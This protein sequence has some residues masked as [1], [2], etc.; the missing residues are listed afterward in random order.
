MSVCVCVRERERGSC[1]VVGTVV[2]EDYQV[3]T[4]DQLSDLHCRTVE[5]VVLGDFQVP[6]L[7]TVD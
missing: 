7:T 5:L 6:V 4:I 2:L 3:T 1:T